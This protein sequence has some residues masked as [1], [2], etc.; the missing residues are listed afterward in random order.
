MKSI[1]DIL[2]NKKIE[3]KN[4]EIIRSF[5]KTKL[6]L[7]NSIQNYEYAEKDQIDYYLYLIKANKA[8][9]DYLIKMAK[10][11]KIQLNN[12]EKLKYDA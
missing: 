9:L 12:I 4:K 2:L 5:L 3:Y 1:D 11:N 10:N 6:E 8:Q 7:N